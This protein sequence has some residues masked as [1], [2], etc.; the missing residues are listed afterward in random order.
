[1]KTL[2]IPS[3]V[4]GGSLPRLV[5][6]FTHSRRLDFQPPRACGCGCL[7]TV[8]DHRCPWYE[9]TARREWRYE[10]TCDS[11]LQSDANGYATRRDVQEAYSA[12]AEL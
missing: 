3:G 9:P 6:R 12:N 2:E 10:V 7:L 5:R 8:I 11:C 1:M 4:E